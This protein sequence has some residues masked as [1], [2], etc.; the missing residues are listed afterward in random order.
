VVDFEYLVEQGINCLTLVQIYLEEVCGWYSLPKEVDFTGQ[1]FYE[2]C[3][4]FEV[5]E[6]NQPV[7]E[8]DIFLFGTAN[9]NQDW[10]KLHLAIFT[11]EYDE[12]R[13]PLLMHAT[14]H[15][16]FLT[17][18]PDGGVFLT[19]LCTMLNLKKYQVLYGVRRLK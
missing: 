12:Q 3:D 18:K 5:I 4:I 17:E 1:F 16:H 10:H 19:P 11:G 14:N 9:L 13:Q 6:P 8:G 2:R 7:R 15:R